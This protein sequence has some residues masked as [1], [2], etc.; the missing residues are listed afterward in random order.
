MP[1]FDKSIHPAFRKA[2]DRSN[3]K[4]NSGPQTPGDRLKQALRT[5]QSPEDAAAMRERIQ[6]GLSGAGSVIGGGLD[7]ARTLGTVVTHVGNAAGAVAGQ[8]AREVTS[9]PQVQETV[10]NIG[11]E[12]GRRISDA[13]GR[14]AAK[15]V[16]RGGLLG[17]NAAR[18]IAEMARPDAGRTG[19]PS[20][21]PY[22]EP[23]A[24]S[25]PE[26]EVQ[27]EPSV[28]DV[29]Y[30]RTASAVSR[31]F[32]RRRSG[33]VVRQAVMG[34]HGNEPDGFPND[35]AGS[36]PEASLATR[37]NSIAANGA[38]AFT[39]WLLNGWQ[40]TKRQLGTDVGTARVVG[41]M[42]IAN[43]ARDAVTG[44]VKQAVKEL[45]EDVALSAIEAALGPE[46]QSVEQEI[47]NLA[48]IHAKHPQYL[49][50]HTHLEVLS[51][52]NR[53]ESWDVG[54]G[55]TG[56][57]V[58]NPLTGRMG[59]IVEI[60]HPDQEDIGPIIEGTFH[61]GAYSWD[62]Y[63]DDGEPTDPSIRRPQP[64]KMRYALTWLDGHPSN[65]WIHPDIAAHIRN[66][67]ETPSPFGPLPRRQWNPDFQSSTAGL[68]VYIQRERERKEARA[69]SEEAIREKY[70]NPNELQKLERKA[71][72]Y[73]ALNQEDLE[74]TKRELMEHEIERY[75]YEYLKAIEE[76]RKRQG[77]QGHRDEF[78]DFSGDESAARAAGPT[79]WTMP[80]ASVMI[81]N[82]GQDH[83]LDFGATEEEE[84]DL[85]GR[86]FSAPHSPEE[87]A[88]YLAENM[89]AMK[90]GEIIVDP[91]MYS[92]SPRA[93]KHRSYSDNPKMYTRSHA[94]LTPDQNI[95]LSEPE[96]ASLFRNESDE[97]Q[98]SDWIE[99]IRPSN[100]RNRS[101]QETPEDYSAWSRIVDAIGDDY[102]APEGM[103][104][105]EWIRRLKEVWSSNATE[106]Y[107][108][109]RL[110][111]E[112]AAIDMENRARKVHVAA[113]RSMNPE[114]GRDVE[115]YRA[116]L[117]DAHHAP[118]A[119]EAMRHNKSLGK[120]FAIPLAKEQHAKRDSKKH[121]DASLWLR[122]QVEMLSDPIAASHI[123]SGSARD[124]YGDNGTMMEN[125]YYSQV[126]PRRQGD[127]PTIKG[128]TES[129]RIIQANDNWPYPDDYSMLG[130]E[131]RHTAG[132]TH[133]RHD[134]DG[135][136]KPALEEESIRQALDSIPGQNFDDKDVELLR[137]AVH[138]PRF[139]VD[140]TI[141]DS[142]FAENIHRN[143]FAEGLK[144][145][146]EHHEATVAGAD[147]ER[148]FD[149]HTRDYH[150]PD[151]LGVNI[152]RNAPEILQNRSIVLRKRIQQM[153]RHNASN[154]NPHEQYSGQDMALAKE[155]LRSVIDL[156][157][158]FR[159][160]PFVAQH[161]QGK[162]MW[163]QT[164]PESPQPSQGE[165]TVKSFFHLTRRSAIQKSMKDK[166][167][168]EENRQRHKIHRE[169]IAEEK[170]GIEHEH[171]HGQARH[172][173]RVMRILDNADD[174]NIW[175]RMDKYTKKELDAIEKEENAE[176]RR[177]HKDH[178][179]P[180][181]PAFV[182][183]Y[184][185][186]IHK[187]KK[188]I[189]KDIL[190]L[191]EQEKNEV[192]KDIAK[193]LRKLKKAIDNVDMS[194]DLLPA[195]PVKPSAPPK[196]PKA[197]AVTPLAKNA[198]TMEKSRKHKKKGKWPSFDVQSSEIARKEKV[199]E[200]A[201]DAIL[202]SRARNHGTRKSL[203]GRVDENG[204]V[205]PDTVRRTTG[206]TGFAAMNRTADQIKA[207][208]NAARIAAAADAAAASSVVPS[209]PRIRYG[210]PIT[211]TLASA[212]GK[213][214][215]RQAGGTFADR[216][217]RV[218]RPPK[219]KPR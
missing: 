120:R 24:A 71:E 131:A 42:N 194:P 116:L 148:P 68:D 67:S 87:R 175:R 44:H 125:G 83:P 19:E 109:H 14:F 108:D 184:D 80:G 174:K 31:P 213:L 130:R 64:K 115:Q 84:R 34:T 195:A 63:D 144:H 217:I 107:S 89:E 11:Q 12:A 73:A 60:S 62:P 51:P 18:N 190:A 206:T 160:N 165:T 3:I 180:G 105:E 143:A 172:E 135:Y 204:F 43:V 154:S 202:A 153:E 4:E 158:R 170:R 72:R 57:Y 161:G 156:L 186:E 17:T 198:E 208:A 167:R 69:L 178:T 28:F 103:S 188:K 214:A 29:L 191:R 215:A 134:S 86:L 98:F 48:D 20:A 192:K 212:R 159:W 21:E 151:D 78:V 205:I 59:R 93:R 199:S 121:Q 95:I 111:A 142:T 22:A 196:L 136:F 100:R 76:Q 41:P 145:A 138:T 13:A 96:L 185:H 113:I 27:R 193:S 139:P 155:E 37:I 179:G 176:A 150:R 102:S 15:R 82:G 23:S 8:A 210:D 168:N 38:A 65:D 40:R 132:F 26:P 218:Y 81:R 126:R 117:S 46:E 39:D 56:Y 92:N 52:I 36:S 211:E 141:P 79:G 54:G 169:E 30:G 114:N 147:P 171:D 207:A 112:S 162:P 183:K 55:H 99:G 187:H 201:A 149:S 53:E 146:R 10:A 123:G 85:I 47:A 35:E 189:K 25:A 127:R 140:E 216:E 91:R 50:Q 128:N 61:G 177:I 16:T 94:A 200:K 49:N 197:A 66:P 90:R 70:S 164:H 157:A 6:A 101:G 163:W 106:D 104:Q 97:K 133:Y 1:W 32:A 75:K 219:R 119:D 129:D 124:R 182:A 152:V 2:E 181:V 77:S 33:S 45:G 5:P 110:Y 173:K 74:K 137:A 166:I 7:A 209:G 58:R 118:T 122:H 203:T 88:R 9:S